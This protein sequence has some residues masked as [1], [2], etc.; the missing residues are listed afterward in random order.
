MRH[1]LGFSLVLGLF[2][3]PANLSAQARGGGRA[4]GGVHVGGAAVRSGP[5]APSTFRSPGTFN[6][7]A[8]PVNRPGV[9]DHRNIVRPVVVAP[10]YY[11]GY[12]SPY[13]YSPYNYGYGYGYG[14]DSNAYSPAYTYSDP[15]Y[16][17]P[18]YSAPEP[19]PSDTSAELAYQVGQLSAQIAELR[20]EQS[21]TTAAASNTSHVGTMTVLIFRD[22]HRQEIQNYAIV[23]QTLW[24]FDENKSTRISLSDLDLA[25]TQNE[26]RLRGVR[27]AAPEQ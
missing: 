4:G 10:F 24:T 23:G 21:R 27:F 12:Y 20:A 5:V 8:V 2:F 11:P 16:T 13:Y 15:S 7:P 3:I 14:Y 19:A 17:A 22:G 1:L 9:I 26:N 25:A 6:R 18:A